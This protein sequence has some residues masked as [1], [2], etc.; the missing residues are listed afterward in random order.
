MAGV[1][2]A[3]NSQAQ[4]CEPTADGLRRVYSWRVQQT[5]GAIRAAE[6][7]FWRGF[8]SAN[9]VSRRRRPSVDEL[10]RSSKTAADSFRRVTDDFR[11]L[12]AISADY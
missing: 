1:L 3:G 10:F 12:L 6:R 11:E 9:I 2:F 8:R 5:C 7:R 4:Q